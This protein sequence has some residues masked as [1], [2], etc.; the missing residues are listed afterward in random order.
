MRR[1]LHVRYLCGSR[2]RP[3]PRLEP[4]VGF[5]YLCLNSHGGYVGDGIYVYNYIRGLPIC[6][7][8]HNI[9]RVRK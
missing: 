1:C 9:D 8:I 4:G 2:S 3:G 7:T 6:T 5:G